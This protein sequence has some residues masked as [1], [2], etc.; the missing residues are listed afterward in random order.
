VSLAA[1]L[2]ALTEADTGDPAEALYLVAM[3][4]NT[5]GQ[6]RG[7]WRS[8]GTLASHARMSRR[9]AIRV[10][11]RLEAA[12]LIRPGDQQLVAHIPS[13]QR[14]RVWDLAMPYRGDTLTPRSDSEVTPETVR[15]DTDTAFEVTPVAHKPRTNP[16]TNFAGAREA[17][18]ALAAARKDPDPPAPD[19]GW[20]P[21]CDQGACMAPARG[22]V[23]RHAQ[24]PPH[25]CK[26]CVEHCLVATHLEQRAA[27]P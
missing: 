8:M 6:G 18:A 4:D 11:Q 24:V 14:P 7:C 10:Q 15:G 5:D 13:N 27:T 3:A 12:G 2:W 25:S 22:W 17:R 21:L 23:A 20:A 16:T 19:E 1:I 9:T 26:Q